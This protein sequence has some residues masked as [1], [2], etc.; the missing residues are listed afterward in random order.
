M[1]VR[2]ERRSPWIGRR[3]LQDEVQQVRGQVV[4][5]WQPSSLR[6]VGS[7]VPPFP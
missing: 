5:H 6:Q 7:P 1:A 4:T 2:G 3:R